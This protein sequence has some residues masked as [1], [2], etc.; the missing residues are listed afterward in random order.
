MVLVDDLIGHPGSEAFVEPDVVPPGGRDQVSEPLVSELVRHHTGGSAFSSQRCS[1]AFHQKNSRTVGHQSG[2]F[3]GIANSRNGYLVQLLEGIRNG[4]IFFE[5]IQ[6]VA[7]GRGRVFRFGAVAMGLNDADRSVVRARVPRVDNVHGSNRDR[8]QIAGEWL[9]FGKFHGLHAARNRLFRE[10]RGVGKCAIVAGNVERSLPGNLVTG[11]VKTWESASRRNLFELG[12]DVPGIAVFDLENSGLVLA[13]DFALIVDVQLRRART[14]RMV[15]RKANQVLGLRD[16]FRIECLPIPSQSCVSH[17]ELFRVQ[18]K[19]RARLFEIEVDIHHPG[20]SILVWDNRE[21]EAIAHRGH[22]GGQTERWR[23]KP[24]FSSLGELAE[25]VGKTAKSKKYEKQGRS[26]VAHRVSLYPRS[27]SLAAR[28]SYAGEALPGSKTKVI[29]HVI[30]ERT[31]TSLQPASASRF[32][33]LALS[34][35]WV[36]FLLA[37]VGLMLAF[38][39][40]L[41]STIL[42]ESG[43]LWG[44][45]ILASAALLLATFVGLT[46]VPYLARRVVASRVREAMDYDVTRAGLIYILISVV[47]GIAAI[48]TG[49]NLLYV[50]VAALLS[51]ILVSGIASALVLR[52]LTLDVHLPEHVLPRGRCWRTCS[53]ATPVRGCHLFPC[54]WFPLSANPIPQPAGAGKPRPSACPATAPL[55]TSGSACP[56]AACGACA[57]QR[58][59]RSCKNPFIFL[60]SLPSRS[61]A[62]TW[63]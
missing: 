29:S 25:G 34:Q 4:K 44:T 57:K 37:I 5:Q 35:V 28:P 27:L 38:G 21:I 33:R 40:A 47:I 49:N 52:S 26:F 39:A 58:K 32:P 11:L 60:F 43:N 24:V 1:I 36:R 2:M 63:K 30:S 19:Q 46:T 22:G 50:I 10:H 59:S 3:H 23:L 48:N 20:E 31:Q 15:E 54:A 18:P 6:N 61:S 9:G 41:F 62:P 55:R 53:W 56:T 45:I 13:A 8:H 42:A 7:R 17:R 12:V 14:D 16:H 51:A